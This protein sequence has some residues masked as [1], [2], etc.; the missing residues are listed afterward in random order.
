MVGLPFYRG[1][2]GPVDLLWK[3]NWTGPLMQLKVGQV[4]HEDQVARRKIWDHP[5]K[6]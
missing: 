2:L 5:S 3:D 4:I 6:L 1:E